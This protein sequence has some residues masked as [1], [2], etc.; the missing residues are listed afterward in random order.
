MSPLLESMVAAAYVRDIDVSRAF[1]ELLGFREHSSGKA[2]NSAWCALQH[3]GHRVL[4]A[5]TRPPLEIPHLPLLFYFF[6]DDLDGAIA[7]LEARGVEVERL[8]RAPHAPGGE[9]RV[10]DPDGNTILLGQPS[11][12]VPGRPEDA[13][14]RFS[15]LREAAAVVAKTGAAPAACQVADER[16]LTCANA[17][18]V[19]LADAAGTSTWACLGHAEEILIVVP[20]AFVASEAD[21]G[22]AAFLARRHG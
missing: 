2:E 12:P 1:Y 8:G 14:S 7:G 11:P 15:L 6:F 22:I 9:A 17:A 3:G 10:T 13:V 5:A 4:L 20:G 19:R 18:E 21:E 16:G